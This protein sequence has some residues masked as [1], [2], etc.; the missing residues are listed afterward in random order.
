MCILCDSIYVLVNQEQIGRRIYSYRNQNSGCLRSRGPDWKGD[1]WQ[2]LK[3][4]KS[5]Y[6]DLG[7]GYMNVYNYQNSLTCTLK[8]RHSILCKIYLNLKNLERSGLWWGACCAIICRFQSH[9][10]FF[11]SPNT[12]CFSSPDS[13]LICGSHCLKHPFF[14][15]TNI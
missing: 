14:P 11:N 13:F 15:L 8:C 4:W 1:L 3:R 7:G 5:L 9:W 6:C 2:F 10:P 12:L